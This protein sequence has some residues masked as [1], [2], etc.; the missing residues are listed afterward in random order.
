MKFDFLFNYI[1]FLGDHKSQIEELYLHK[2]YIPSVIIT[3]IFLIKLYH[4][5]NRIFEL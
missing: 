3:V 2:F 1:M 4:Q 5:V